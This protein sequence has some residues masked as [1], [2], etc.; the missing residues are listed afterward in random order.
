MKNTILFFFLLLAA[1]V[2]AQSNSFVT[3]RLRAA[4]YFRIGTNTSQKVTGFDRVITAPGTHDSLPTSRAVV[5]FLEA[6]FTPIGYY[7]AGTGISISDDVITN[8]APDQVVGLTGAGITVI[9]GTYPNFTITSNEVDGSTTNELQTLSI[10]G[11]DLTLSNGGG[12]VTIPLTTTLDASDIVVDNSAFSVI[13]ATD[14][15]MAFEQTDAA[16]SNTLNTATSFGG[17]ISGTYD[18]LQL[19]AGAVG[20]SEIADNSVANT[21]LRQSAGLSVMGR[22][23][24]TTGNVADITASAANAVLRYDGSILGWGA[25]N[26]ASSNAVTGNLPVTN[27]NSGTGATSSTYWRGD[28]TWGTPTGSITGSGTS[29]RVAYWNGSSTLTSSG[30]FLYNGTTLTVNPG[31]SNYSYLGNGQMELNTS[32]TFSSNYIL[33]RAVLT[34]NASASNT[35]VDAF[36]S[37]MNIGTTG[38]PSNIYVSGIRTEIDVPSGSSSISANGA[39]LAV[40]NFSPTPLGLRGVNG[41]ISNFAT[42]GDINFCNGL[43]FDVTR[44][45]D[46]RDAHT[47][48]GVNARVLDWSSGRWKTAYAIDAEVQQAK[49]SYGINVSLLNSRGIGATQ[50]GARISS[51]VSGAGTVADN[52]YGISLNVSDAGTGTITNYYGISLTSIPASTSSAWYLYNSTAAKSYLSGDV[53]VGTSSPTQKLHVSGNARLTGALYDGTNSA[54]SSGNVL[55]STGGGTQWKSAAS[56]LAGST[57]VPTG[58]SDPLGSTGDFSYDSNYIYVKTSAGWKRTALSTF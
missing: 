2:S 58:T 26:L 22:S 20:T 41:S 4:E 42:S 6:N 19:G 32:S 49:S 51:T 57:Y 43:Q 44:Y 53:G 5:D 39:S 18:D 48:R 7:T 35:N 29:G 40:T 17:D 23:A 52:V 31:A 30:N 37:Y 38:S 16:L 33:N 8:S 47:A 10:V 28:G 45:D 54:G 1:A 3:D 55:T 27:L 36:R 14:A 11:Q 34:G 50:Y 9:T 24:A 13:T 25:V 21:N 46:S 12:T 56:V 15:Q